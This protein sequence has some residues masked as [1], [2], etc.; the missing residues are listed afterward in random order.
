MQKK[1]TDL[2]DWVALL[3]SGLYTWM[4]YYSNTPL[5]TKAQADFVAYF[6]TAIFVL[7]IAFTTFEDSIILRSHY[8]HPMIKAFVQ[9]NMIAQILLFV[10]T[11]HF[12][13]FAMRVLSFAIMHVRVKV[14]RERAEEASNTSRAP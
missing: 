13:L 12:W 7:S 4:I 11:A 6:T 8:R 1:N 2:G 10:V 3:I 14:A 5:G 9:T